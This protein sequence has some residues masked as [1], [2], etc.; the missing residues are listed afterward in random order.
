MRDIDR[1]ERRRTITLGMIRV[2]QQLNIDVVAEVVERAEELAI[3]KAADVP[4]VQGYHLA[5][6]AVNALIRDDQL[7]AAGVW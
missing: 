2:C 4:Y 3:L 5:R 7:G 6:P 1:D